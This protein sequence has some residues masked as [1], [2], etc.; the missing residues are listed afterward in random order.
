M[1]IAMS[2]LT[3]DAIA[4]DLG[5]EVVG[6]VVEYR[7]E[8]ASTMDV[9][10]AAARDGAPDGW[11]IVADVQTAGRGRF[12]RRWLTPPGVSIAVSIVLRPDERQRPWL[13][14]LAAL[15]AAR[16]IEA[17]TGLPTAL[18]WPNDILVNGRKVGGV[19]VEADD[20]TAIFG[21][22]INVNLDPA[23]HV[24]TAGASSLSAEAGAPMSRLAVLRALLQEMDGLWLRLRRGD[25]IG[26]EWA[27]RLQTLG[28]TVEVDTGSGVI[29]GVA[30]AVDEV[31]ALLVRD[32]MGQRHRFLAGEVTMHR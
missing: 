3:A 23:A 2:E 1:P 32:A 29:G 4:R 6:C 17:A 7:A 27:A 31:G 22:G 21:I 11:A 5:A 8:V 16:A 12:G 30:E 28:E 26:A 18:K 20:N 25:A 13:S 9:A 14:P 15:A 24:E 10:R 19:L